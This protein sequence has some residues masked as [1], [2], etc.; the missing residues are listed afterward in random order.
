MSKDIRNIMLVDDDK[1]LSA[2]V[3]EYLESKGFGCTLCHNVRDAQL[4]LTKRKYHLCLLDVKMPM[5]DGFQLAETLKQNYSS[6]PFIFLTSQLSTA[7]RIKGLEAGAQDYIVKPFSIREL[8]LRIDNV[9]KRHTSKVKSIHEEN[10]EIKIGLIIF[11]PLQRKLIGKKETIGLTWIEVKLLQLFCDSK[12][13][14]IK[15][16]H[17]LHSIWADEHHFK[18]RSLNVYISRLRQYL[19]MDSNIQIRNIHGKGYQMTVDDN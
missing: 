9:L 3:K 1:P 18:Q 15:R 10:D 16:E 13:G 4:A 8:S 17:A 14:I 2:V 7:D 19:K 11:Y 12:D 6:I 5:E